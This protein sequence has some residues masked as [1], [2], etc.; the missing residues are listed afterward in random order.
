MIQF[1]D[2]VTKVKGSRNV[3]FDEIELS[4]VL[5]DLNVQAALHKDENCTPVSGNGRPLHKFRF[6]LDSGAHGNLIPKSMFQRLYPGLPHSELRKSI[7]KQVTLVAYNKQEI[8]QLGQCCVNVCNSSMGKSKTCKFFVVEDK[9]NPIIGLN[10]SIALQLLS[11]NVP[12]TDKW[13][14]NVHSKSSHSRYDEMETEEV[15]Q[16]EGQLTRDYI[17]KRYSKLFKGIGRFQC[18]PAKIQLK[19]NAVPVQKPARHIL[20]ALKEEFQKEINTMVH[21]GILTKLDKNQATEWLNSFVVVRKPSGK[22]R[23]CLDPTDLNPHI[24]RPV[25]N[26]NT[27]DDIIHK[28]KHTKHYAVFDA[29]KGFFHVPLDDKSKLLTAMLTPLGVFIYNVLAMGLS[30]VNDIFEQCL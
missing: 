21:D 10:D 3:M 19:S 28:L 26:S 11:V 4:R 6:K 12:F 1:T 13:T 17:L 7:D 23:I 27:L 14:G 25:C 9:C 29:I 30:N 22:L 8:K 2:S 20:V 18:T 15:G 24:I 5:V 16:Q